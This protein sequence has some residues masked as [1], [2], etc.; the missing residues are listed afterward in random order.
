M[1]IDFLGAQG[2]AL[3]IATFTGGS[4][5]AGIM[6]KFIITPLKIERDESVKEL[7]DRLIG[8]LDFYRELEDRKRN[9]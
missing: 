9:A 3:A 5:V 8:E 6:W 1:T 4:F 2:G 7:K